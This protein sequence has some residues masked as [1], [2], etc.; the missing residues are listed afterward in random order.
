MSV[1]KFDLIGRGNGEIV[2]EG[3]TEKLQSHLLFYS[4]IR[5]SRVSD[6]Q[7]M[8]R[9]PQAEGHDGGQR[10]AYKGSR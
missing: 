4:E 7:H 1:V 8:V 2:G 6:P 3:K 10:G 5:E 9:I